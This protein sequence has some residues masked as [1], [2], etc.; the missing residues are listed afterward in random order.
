MIGEYE[1]NQF[2]IWLGQNCIVFRYVILNKILPD[3]LWIPILTSKVDPRTKIVKIAGIQMKR[4]KQTKIIMK[5]SNW[6]KPLV[7]MAYTNT[8]LRCKG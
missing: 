7:P 2:E 8:F 4:K 5:I 6:K 1:Y 3:K